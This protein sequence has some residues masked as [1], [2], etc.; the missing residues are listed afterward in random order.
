MSCP[1]TA[2]NDVEPSDVSPQL[3]AVRRPTT[4][5]N[6]FKMSR[7]AMTVGLSPKNGWVSH[8]AGYDVAR[9]STATRHFVALCHPDDIDHVLH[10]GRLNYYKSYEYELL[11]AI[12]GVS[13]F[14]D[15]ED[16]WQRYRTMLSPM[17]AK[18]H[19]NG[20]VDLMI[21]PIDALLTD[22]GQRGPLFELEMVNEMVELTLNVV[23]N[24]LFSQGFGPVAAKMSSKVTGGLRF[25]ERML[26]LFLVTAPPK[27]VW[28]GLSRVAFTPLPIPP[29]FAG[30]Q[31][32][33]KH[34][35]DAVWQLTNE[36][37]EHPIDTPDLLNHL[38]NASD[39]GG[40][41]PMK[42]IRDEAITLMLAGHETT[43]NAL[44]W[45]WYLLA[46][47]PDARSRMLDEV[48][49]VLQGRTPTAD[50]LSTLPWTTAVFLEAM[51]YFS[52]AWAIPR[53]AVHDDVVGDQAIPKGTTVII[54]AHLVHHDPRWWPNPEQFDPSRFLPGAGK[55]RP[56]S[57]Y[58]PFGG[59][60]RSCIGQ[61]FATMESV[62]ITAMLSQRYVFDLVPGHP[63][64]PEAT[65]TLRPRHG[66]KMFARERKISA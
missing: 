65:L 54:P 49:T 59:G 12:L 57:A 56:R 33:V 41:M 18:R 48:D 63:V 3:E 27:K 22:Y 19:L 6:R 38:L 62:L 46:L 40:A 39:E 64:E 43:A 36:R 13:L 34:I 25:G 52:P 4:T 14:T 24:S 61:G 31:R 21:E 44:S 42:R 55:D 58:L 26:R 35:D 51:R 47:N 15:E 20:L 2:S 53:V 16:S 66:L 1:V 50:D 45:M 7:D 10:A 32:I 11:R 30:I 23:G 37:R 9:F 60:K 5:L 17:F 29:P 8:I 28:R